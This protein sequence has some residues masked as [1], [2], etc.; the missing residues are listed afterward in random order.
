[1][2]TNVVRSAAMPPV[3]QEW[4]D[5]IGGPRRAMMLGVG[6]AAAVL[7]FAFSRWATAPEWVPLFTG[8]PLE[9]AGRVTERLDE[10][11]IRY[12]LDRGGTEVRVTS[13]DLPRARVML[14]G[15]G[16]PSAGRPG[17]ELFDQPSW[18]MTDF[19]QRINYRRALEGELERTIGRMRGVESAKVHLA[20]HENAS[21]RRA[22]RPAEA[23]VVLQL[24]SGAP[25]AP[26]VVQGIAHL[27][28]GSI[29]GLNPERVTVLDDTGRMLSNLHETGTLAGL[30]SRQLGVQREIEAYLEAKAEEIVGRIVGPGNARIQVAAA[31]NFDRLERT[32]ETL[33][34]D[35]QALASEQRAEIIPG[36][37]GG[38]GSTNQ[39]ATYENSRSL[40]TYASATGT[41][42]RLS[43]AVLVN[44]REIPGEG[45]GALQ[46]R[47]PDELA[48]IEALVRSAVGFDEQRGD[49]VSVVSV[50]F[51]GV[52][53]PSGEVTGTDLWTVVATLQRPLITV[54]ALLLAFVVALKTIRTLGSVPGRTG[55]TAEFAGV[56]AAL[57]PSE[58]PQ[59]GGGAVPPVAA[60]AMAG[61]MAPA[62]EPPPAPPLLPASSPLRQS[63]AAGVN[64]YPDLAARLVREWLKEG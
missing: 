51:D 21:F 64:E 52:R 24:S 61:A 30:T 22:D 26:E 37:E 1:V 45:G 20:I 8:M 34:P 28:A 10:A 33:D 55:A 15:E 43:V 6:L 14:A 47:S 59:P 42:R 29:D 39:A 18:G 63:V 44:D 62:L 19:T 9:T 50:P 38:A 27:V 54:L 58:A 36:P 25:A 40:E 4:M 53:I 7:I 5:R 23:S 12:E 32:T 56:P 60:P 3:V 41:V 2:T 48:R 13:A 17:L 57:A 46:P 11:G 35:R 16:L 49:V 31:V